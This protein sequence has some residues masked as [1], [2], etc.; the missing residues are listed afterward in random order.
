MKTNLP[1]WFLIVI[2]ILAILNPLISF[3][4]KD[5]KKKKDKVTTG[6][7]YN[8]TSGWDFEY[9]KYKMPK[10]NKEAKKYFEGM[11]LVE[12][13]TFSM[14]RT[15]SFKPE[16][17][18]TTL[19]VNNTP[20]RVTVSSFYISDHEVTNGEY[21]EFVN[22]VIDSVRLSFLAKSDPSF[23]N[24]PSLKTL[25]WDKKNEIFT[26]ENMKKLEPLYNLVE[27]RFYKKQEFNA[28]F[29]IYSSISDKDTFSV[30]IYPDT[31]RWLLEMPYSYSEPM[32]NAYFWHPAYLN[33]PVVGVNFHQAMAYCMW[34]TKMLNNAI[35]IA[36]KT[37]YASALAMEETILM[38]DFRLPTEAEWEYAAK[39]DASKAKI[40]DNQSNYDLFPWSENN[41]FDEKGN[42][43]AN[44]GPIHDENNFMIKSF[45]QY[46]KTTKNTKKHYEGDLYF[47]PT[48][49]K[50]FAANGFGLYDMAGNVAEWVMDRYRPV[51]FNCM[52]DFRP[53]RG[54]IYTND[55]I[56]SALLNDSSGNINYLDGYAAIESDSSKYPEKIKGNDDVHVALKKII[57]KRN[58]CNEEERVDTIKDKD[59]WLYIAE[60]EVHNARVAE[61]YPDAR[62]IKGG[63]WATGPVYMQCGAREILS[64]KSS[65]T[66]VGFR[67][68]MTCAGVA[69]KS[70]S[71]PDS[72]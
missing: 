34:K 66:R 41:L 9:V 31:T 55:S 44:F 14:G 56:R 1:K 8:D 71:S 48:L 29:A 67:I 36:H 46:F 27:S 51:N 12:G 40:K 45:Q 52:N 68:A 38:P 18:D 3:S 5:K 25:N 42:Y 49:V 59:R 60:G 4:Q 57:E 35:C 21:R 20:R 30:S 33:Y 17:T 69:I 43:Y 10:L 16:K 50:L 22:W 63:S 28:K 70:N 2:L 58:F 39:A 61:R 47:Y 19:I 24:D 11:K 54:N 65:S 6:W 13:G 26:I 37:D 62:I 32:Q 15:S 64:E 53:F 7:E 23:Y 72:D